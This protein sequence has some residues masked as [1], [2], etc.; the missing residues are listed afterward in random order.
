MGLSHILEELKPHVKI[1]GPFFAE[2][3][4]LIVTIRIRRKRKNRKSRL[5]NN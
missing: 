2:E 4:Q 5:P 1:R 3:V